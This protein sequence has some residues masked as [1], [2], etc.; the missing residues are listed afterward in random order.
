MQ[1]SDY[2]PTL[3]PVNSLTIAFFAPELEYCCRP[4]TAT[5]SPCTVQE[6]LQER[7]LF[8]RVL[9]TLIPGNRIS[10]FRSQ[11]LCALKGVLETLGL[12]TFPPLYLFDLLM[13]MR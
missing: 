11:R 8:I 7:L 5:P 10:H 3:Y 12:L 6:H 9:G 13:S 2:G 4:V 1:I